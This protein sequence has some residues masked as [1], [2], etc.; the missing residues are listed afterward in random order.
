MSYRQNVGKLE[1]GLHS[2]S[3]VSN[4]ELNCCVVYTHMCVCVCTG[5]CAA[6]FSPASAHS[7]HPT[8]MSAAAGPQ[9]R[10][11]YSRPTSASSRPPSSASR[12]TSAPS[13]PSS[14]AASRP[15]SAASR[16]SAPAH[17]LLRTQTQAE[18]AAGSGP[19]TPLP[20]QVG[21]L[22]LPFRA[23]LLFLVCGACWSF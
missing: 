20:A 17:P 3:G 18:T 11:S 16:L 6:N 21:R 19:S 8:A 1:N 14:S 7:S 22:A 15:T 23:L 5:S 4:K 13:R 9:R 2:I 10:G 12:P